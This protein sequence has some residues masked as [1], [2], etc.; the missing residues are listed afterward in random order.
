MML[1]LNILIFRSLVGR[2]IEYHNNDSV[3]IGCGDSNDDNVVADDE[4]GLD[5]EDYV[6]NDDGDDFTFPDLLPGKCQELKAGRAIFP[7]KCNV[8]S[9]FCPILHPSEKLA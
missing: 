7:H 9:N 4:D 1:M 6:D 5:D 8:W 3:D 2:H